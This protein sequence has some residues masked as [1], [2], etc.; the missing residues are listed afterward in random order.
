M[1]GTASGE[2]LDAVYF[3][4]HKFLG[5]PG[6]SGVLVCDH[7]LHRVARPTAPGGGTVRY[8]TPSNQHYV[9]DV[10]QL[11][12]AGT[13]AIIGDIRAGLVVELKSDIGAGAIHAIE[14]MALD[15]ALRRWSR[16]PGIELLGP[17]TADRLPIIAFNIRSGGQLLHH[18]LVVRLL[19]D[20]FGIQA[21]G[22]CSCAGPYGH[23]LLGIDEA[24]S[25]AYQALIDQGHELSKPGWVRLGF[26]FTMP[27]ET[28]TFILEAV[29][30]IARHGLALQRLYTADAST[31]LWT[32]QHEA[33][34][35]GDG[36]ERLCTW[37]G[38]TAPPAPAGDIP[39]FAE[40]FRRAEAIVRN[41]VR[42]M[43]TAVF[44]A[45]TANH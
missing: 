20:L 38:T 29:A 33:N 13:P 21:R 12:E 37:R 11:E 3:S 10:E 34:V 45:A 23:E 32:T 4:P 9:D 28:V 43:G 19:N 7:Q 17:R 25:A 41:G 26:H 6:A 44:D 18:N 22:G 31:G 40:C 30:F 24:Q 27:E 5:G 14:Q 15:R 35:A 16:E 2:H 39:S 42:A 36:W 1:R 8:V